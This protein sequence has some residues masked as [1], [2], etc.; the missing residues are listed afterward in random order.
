MARKRKVCGPPKKTFLSCFFLVKWYNIS[1]S[2]TFKPIKKLLLR[3]KNV[4]ETDLIFGAFFLVKS[5]IYNFFILT[6]TGK[7]KISFKC[8]GFRKL[9]FKQMLK[10]L[11]KCECFLSQTKILRSNE[12]KF[13]FFKTLVFRLACSLYLSFKSRYFHYVLHLNVHRNI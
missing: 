8:T 5:L 7:P 13:V 4:K 9:I 3:L 6:V 2:K 11:T 1:H 12:L 10:K